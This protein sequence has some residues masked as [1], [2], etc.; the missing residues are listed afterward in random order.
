MKIGLL[1][2]YTLPVK[3]YG[4]TERVVWSLAKA[5]DKAGHQVTLIAGK[6]TSAPFAHVVETDTT[7]PAEERVPKDL[8]IVHFQNGVPASYR[9]KSDLG[10]VPPYVVT[11]HGNGSP[12]GGADPWSIYVSEN[13]AIRHGASAFVHNGIDWEDY[14]VF[15]PGL[16][17]KGF[18]FLGNAAWRV[19]NVKGA[20]KAARKAGD[21]LEVL[22]GNRLN[23]KMGF[24]LTL[25]LRVHFH[26]MVDD[27]EKGYVANRSRGLLF[28]VKWHEPFGLAVTEA[29]YFGAPVFATPYGSLPELVV[30]GTG[31]L[32]ED[33]DEL[34]LAARDFRA[35]ERFIHEYAADMFNADVMARKYLMY[36]GQRLDGIRF[37]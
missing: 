1:T 11:M 20:I 5:L 33:I 16:K 4:G 14:P 30:P 34:A 32:S 19:K 21:T 36:Y 29:M 23:I 15:T 7:L 12:P 35:D 8:D 10:A 6:G 31:F 2:D 13:H 26:G 9:E 37:R 22:G 27:A 25:D 3:R 24:R 18:F 28:P 17:R